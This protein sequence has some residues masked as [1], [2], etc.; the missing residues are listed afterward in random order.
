MRSQA[1]AYE[2][3]VQ[4]SDGLDGLGKVDRDSLPVQE[5]SSSN[6]H[7]SVGR[8]NQV[9]HIL[10]VLIGQSVFTAPATKGTKMDVCATANRVS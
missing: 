4:I 8:V 9:V 6:G 7:W 3:K 10:T 5:F 1:G 2:E